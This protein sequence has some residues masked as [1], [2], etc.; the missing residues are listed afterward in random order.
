MAGTSYDVVVNYSSTGDIGGSLERGI[1]RAKKKSDDWLKDFSRGVGNMA[2]SFNSAFDSMATSAAS[3]IATLGATIGAGLGVAMGKA[4]HESF[5]FNEESENA[6]LSMAA[7]FNMT[8]IGKGTQDW[9]GAPADGFATG[10]NLAQRSIAQM[11]RDARELPGEFKDLQNIMTTVA[12]A[13][14]GAGLDAWG[15]EKF[16]ARTMLGAAMLGVNQNVAAREMAMLLQGNA[17]HN[18][19]LFNRLNLGMDTKAF[20]KLS[21]P[22]RFAAINTQLKKLE[23]SSDAVKNSWATIKSNATDTLRQSVGMAGYGLF[24][25]VKNTLKSALD[26]KEGTREKLAAFGEQVSDYLVKAFDDGEKAIIKWYPAVFTF[27]RHMK[28]GLEQVFSRFSGS[29]GGLSD[30]V[31]GFLQDPEAFNKIERVLGTL[32]ALRAGSGVLSGIGDATSGGMGLAKGL[33]IA[34]GGAELAVVGA[35]AAGALALVAFAAGGAASAYFDSTSMFHNA[36]V[37]G[38]ASVVSSTSELGS[39]LGELWNSVK[40]LA[41]MLGVGLVYAIDSTINQ[42]THVVDALTWFSNAVGSMTN[43]I[44]QKVG[45]KQGDDEAMARFRASAGVESA[46]DDVHDS[47]VNGALANMWGSNGGAPFTLKPDNAFA[48]ANKIPPVN[49][50]THIHNVEIKVE[51]NEDPDRVARVTIDKLLDLSRNP[52][53]SPADPRSALL[54]GRSF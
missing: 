8:G 41:E 49:H 46:M 15:L 25:R 16:S 17:R 44:L 52:R 40:P 45:L 19:P 54:N 10:M 30:R 51:G 3:K 9:Q 23:E 1:G 2:S 31:F 14:A 36:T 32:G 42:F 38:V 11:R 35:A 34:T 39:S 20:N 24:D 27:V 28:E 13:A 5:K 22:E 7:V 47:I 26:P 43:W 48:D 33:G 18:M 53:T 4:L 37:N 21:E 29:L 50:T 6:A 12:P